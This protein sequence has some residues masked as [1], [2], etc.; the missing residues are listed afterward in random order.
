MKITELLEIAA[1]VGELCNSEKEV[2]KQC[3]H[4]Q[5]ICLCCPPPPPPRLKCEC[6]GI[7]RLRN[8]YMYSEYCCNNGKYNHKCK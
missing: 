1:A 6:Y 3:C 8:C 2:E 5:P 7:T 4:C